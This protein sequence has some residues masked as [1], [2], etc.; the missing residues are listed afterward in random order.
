MIRDDIG[1]SGE[2]L[3]LSLKPGSPSP[4]RGAVNRQMSPSCHTRW[5]PE[6]DSP[7]DS[8]LR[9][10]AYQLELHTLPDGLT[11]GLGQGRGDFIESSERVHDA[12]CG[13]L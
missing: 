12:P 8:C 4:G 7:P 10:T 6:Q 2:G 11:K 1:K 3:P 9:I 13:L 5:F